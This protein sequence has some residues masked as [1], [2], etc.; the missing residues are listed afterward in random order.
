M[1]EQNTETKTIQLKKQFPEKVDDKNNALLNALASFRPDT[2]SVK[3]HELIKYAGSTEK[4]WTIPDETLEQYGWTT[5]LRQ[6]FNEHRVRFNIENELQK[7]YEQNISFVSF[8]SP[9]YPEI[10]RTI[11]DPPLGLYVRGSLPKSS[12]NIAFVGS[13]KATPYG[14][15]ATNMLVRPLAAKGVTIVSGLAYGIDAEAHRAT[16][17]VHGTL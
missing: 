2:T 10:L 11:F 5:E 8:Y 13:R 17:S 14:K 15:T 12:L 3:L 16:L 7:L 4:A 6:R 1:Q 9:Q